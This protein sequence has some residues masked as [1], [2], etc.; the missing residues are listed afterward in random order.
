MDEDARL[1]QAWRD[2][3]QQ[4]A[5]RLVRRRLPEI[6]RFFRNKVAEES[7][8]P[9][10]VSQTFE[11][12]LAGSGRFRGEA[13]VRRYLYAVARHVLFTYLRSKYKRAREKVDFARLSL[14][15]VQP[16]TPSSMLMRKRELRALVEGLRQVPVD[17]QILLELRFF[18]GLTGPA[19]A[20]VL[21]V[22]EGTVRGRLARATARL[23]A[24]VEHNLNTG[25]PENSVALQ[26]L[27]AWAEEV[28]Q[29]LT[30]Q[31]SGP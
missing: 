25:Q 17:D 14:H 28:R 6:S 22:P 2:G 12:V 13:S 1:L 9:D 5:E 24:A 23:R 11:G 29:T 19:L 18:E 10:L 20:E 15:A 26:T 16:V 31:E 4:A 21:E 7:D 3:D 8:L 30:A 27:E